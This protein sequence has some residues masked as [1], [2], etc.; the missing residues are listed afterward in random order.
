MKKPVLL[1]VIFGAAVAGF[2][3]TWHRPAPVPV[4]APSQPTAPV[5]PPPAPKSADM[6]PVPPPVAPSN[7]T[8]AAV[9]DTAK[10]DAATNAIHVAVDAL[11]ASK[12]PRQKHELFQQLLQAGQ[13]DQAIVDLQQRMAANPN[14]PEIPTT[15]GEALL[16]KVRATLEA[17]GG[18]NTQDIAIMA[19][20]ADQ[21]FD[22]ALKI[23]PQNW[24][25]EFV[26]NA[27]MV[28]WPAN[29][30]MDNQVVQNLSNLI[31]QQG[32]MPS[33]PE[34]AQTYLILGNEY[35]KI[36]QPDKALV[37][38]KLGAQQFPNDPALQQKLA[39]AAG[40]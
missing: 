11:L 18:Q 12:S 16:N 3:S 9:V 30:E 4:V 17:N 14:D 23:D 2:L 31:D 15:L 26:K 22:T 33:Q 34:F 38:W 24:E 27:S 28:H 21:D 37:T 5:E 40:N 10:P 13:L 25:A 36:G 29:P 7:T 6:L 20:Q 35:E 19:L 39:G 32:N 8:P 1:L